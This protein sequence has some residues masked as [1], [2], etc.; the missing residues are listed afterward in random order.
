MENQKTN[1]VL[2]IVMIGATGAV[3]GETLNKLRELPELSR[4]TL[5]GRQ[6]IAY[7]SEA[8][9]TQQKINIFDTST[10]SQN[11]NGHQ[12]AICTLGVGQPSKIS[13]TDFIKVDKLAVLEFAKVCKINRVKHFQL[14]ASVGISSRSSSYYLK[15]K[16]ELVDE[17]IALNFEKLSVFQP[18]MIITPSNRYGF[19]QGVLLRIWPF[20]KPIL[21]GSLKKYRGISVSELGQAIAINSLNKKNGIEYL[22]WKGFKSINAGIVQP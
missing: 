19:S 1:Q 2:S 6:P 22:T 12:T 18:S 9:I 21:L 14:L 13:K 17:L 10:Y 8:Y 20:L 11:I 5:L 3:G 4:L 7:I 15:T 16:G